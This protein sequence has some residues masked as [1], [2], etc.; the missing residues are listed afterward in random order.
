MRDYNES[1][2]KNE[3]CDANNTN[4]LVGVFIGIFLIF[5]AAYL[6][7]N[8]NSKCYPIMNEVEKIARAIFAGIFNIF[9]LVAYFLFWS[10]ECMSCKL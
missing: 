3:R 1:C 10:N 5:A 7:Y 9:Y 6:S 4:N 2:D 8:C